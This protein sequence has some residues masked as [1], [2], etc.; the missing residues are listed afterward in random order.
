MSSEKPPPVNQ[1]AIVALTKELE[2]V[3]GNSVGVA[4]FLLSRY[5]LIPIPLVPDKETLR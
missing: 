3:T 5:E 2:P 4:K 1:A